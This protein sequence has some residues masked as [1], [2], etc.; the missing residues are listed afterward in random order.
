MKR[1]LAQSMKI[2]TQQLEG[3]LKGIN[4]VGDL[5]SKI[6]LF[7]FPL[8]GLILL[9]VLI[10]GGFDFITSQGSPE[11]IKSAWAKITTGVIGFALLVLSMLFVRLIAFIFGLYTGIL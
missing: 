9:F 10:W 3:P 7:L 6:L 5:I 1:L 8:A 2:G 4:T 11:K